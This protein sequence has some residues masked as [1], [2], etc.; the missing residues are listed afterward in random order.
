MI[1]HW[2]NQTFTLARAEGRKFQGQ[3]DP[4]LRPFGLSRLGDGHSDGIEMQRVISPAELPTQDEV[5]PQ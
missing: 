3:R 4:F 5:A 2:K 1:R